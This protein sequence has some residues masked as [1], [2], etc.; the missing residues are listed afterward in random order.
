MVATRTTCWKNSS[1]HL[2]MV[3]YED[4]NTGSQVSSSSLTVCGCG[5][6]TDIVFTLLIST[7]STR[8]AYPDLNENNSKSIAF[9]TIVFINILAS[10]SI[11]RHSV[12]RVVAKIYQLQIGVYWNSAA[13]ESKKIISHHLSPIIL[14]RN[15]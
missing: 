14:R 5:T 2:S 3:V 7:I 12:P 6:G 15:S 1:G 4:L 8:F 10:S 11:V 13:A 9:F